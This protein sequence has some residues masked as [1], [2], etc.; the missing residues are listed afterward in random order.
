MILLDSYSKACPLIF[1]EE[2]IFV[3]KLVIIGQNRTIEPK[4]KTF[5]RYF[6]VLSFSLNN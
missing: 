1:S 4:F 3:L 5:L 6:V 2:Y